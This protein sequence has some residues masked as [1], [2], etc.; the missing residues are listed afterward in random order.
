MEELRGMP[1]N[2]C[3]VCALLLQI[4]LAFH[5]AGKWQ[6]VQL[7]ILDIVRFSPI[8]YINLLVDPY[9]ISRRQEKH[10]NT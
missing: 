6:V 2:I 10:Q 8:N 4:V 5:F 9:I 3:L 1:I 7:S